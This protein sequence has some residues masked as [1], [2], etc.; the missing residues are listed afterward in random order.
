M[1]NR[2]RSGLLALLL[3][4]FTSARPAH[5][6]E[7][8]VE[9]AEGATRLVHVDADRAIEL[10]IA[11]PDP[12]SDAPRWRRVCS[13]PCDI[14]LPIQATYRLD[15]TGVRTTLPFRLAGR[16]GERVV[17]TVATASTGAFV[18]GTILEIAGFVTA[19]VGALV[20][21]VSLFAGAY[22]PDAPPGGH[23]KADTEAL[24]A[25]ASVLFVGAI[26]AAAGIVVRNH[27]KRSSVTLG[28]DADRRPPTAAWRE[29]VAPTHASQ[30]APGQVLIPVWTTSF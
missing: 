20:T 22:D 30:R 10:L 18:G 9:R 29:T 12:D 19:G 4:L 28:Y 27:N 7:P 8:L 25:G 23:K 26:A 21:V 11:E 15:G 24:V 1:K 5:A 13:A 2:S 3:F 17:V 16:P 6:Q 14:P